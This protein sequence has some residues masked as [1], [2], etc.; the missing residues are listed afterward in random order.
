GVFFNSRQG[1][2]VN[3][4][5]SM[6]SPFSPTVTLNPPPGPFSN[7]FLGIN[8]PFP[9]PN[10]SP[11]DVV[12]PT[13]VALASWDPYHQLLPSM[14]YNFNL[15]SE[16]QLRTDWLA[17]IAYVGTRTNHLMTTEEENPGQYFPGSTLGT[18]ARRIFI[19]FGS[20]KLGS[21]SGNSWYNSLQLSLEKRL[22][23]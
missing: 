6:I 5:Q 17:R 4:S 14:A 9:L 22:S 11:K 12:V 21:A 23:R 19:P 18:D 20:I 8:N 7:P 1:G 13:P 16:R 3:A 10:P 2:S 15:P